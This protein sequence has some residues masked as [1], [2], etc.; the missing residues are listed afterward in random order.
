MAVAVLRRRTPRPAPDAAEPGDVGTYLTP[1][2]RRFRQFVILAIISYFLIVPAISAI[3]HHVTP[4][5]VFMVAG[6]L[7]FV[8]L[9]A[10]AVILPVS[11]EAG[12]VQWAVLGVIVALA[13]ALFVVGT[14]STADR[15]AESWVTIL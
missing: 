6:S 12:R 15:N 4:A 7:V 13:I 11:V 5:T 8:V 1:Q 3:W 10:K 2:G 14:L 9:V